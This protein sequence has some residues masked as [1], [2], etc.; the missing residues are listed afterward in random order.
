MEQVVLSTHVNL[1]DLLDT[2]R[3]G[4]R[5]KIFDTEEELSEYTCETKKFFPLDSA[6]QGGVLKYLLRHIFDPEDEDEDEDGDED[7]D[8]EDGDED[9]DDYEGNYEDDYEDDCDGNYEGN[10]GDD[11][12]DDYEG[13]Y[14]DDYEDDCE[15]YY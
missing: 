14:G 1:V 4:Q 7:G 11:Y 3:T 13:N 9:G 12:E 2:H 5:V 10:Y 6:K 15:D 8:D